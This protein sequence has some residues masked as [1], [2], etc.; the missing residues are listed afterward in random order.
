MS[1]RELATVTY[2][3]GYAGLVQAMRERAA[4]R[5]IALTGES[6][7]AASGL[8][9]FYIQKLLSPSRRP[10]RRFGMI[11]LG[12]VLGVLALKLVVVPDDEAAARFGPRIEQK[13]E[14]CG[15]MLTVKA[16]RGKQQMVSVRFL[17]RIA[18]SGGVARNHA[19]SPARRRQ[20]ARKAAQARWARARKAEAA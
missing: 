5:R 1:E 11:S 15:R 8:A 10:M 20:I 12:P 13:S 3:N 19:L 9:N 6:V 4:E 17:R 16:G 14:S 2:E 7:A 18:H